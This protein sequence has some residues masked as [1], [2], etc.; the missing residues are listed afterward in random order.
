[1]EILDIAWGPL[2]PD[3]WHEFLEELPPDQLIFLA[4]L[5]E[6]GRLEHQ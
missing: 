1:M 6:I 2:P 4:S 3:E 5:V